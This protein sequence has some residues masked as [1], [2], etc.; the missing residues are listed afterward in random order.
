MFS[1][2]LPRRGACRL[3]GLLPIFACALSLELPAADAGSYILTPRPGPAPKINGPAVYGV[4]PGRPLLYRIPCTG[5]RPIRFSAEPLPGS[6]RLDAV[7]G[8]LTG[9]AP[10]KAGEYA[11]TLRAT[12]DHGQ[13]TKR[14]KIVVG[15]TLALTPPMGWN[16]WYTHYDRITDKLL[17]QAADAMVSSGMADFGYQYVNID[18]CWMVKPNSTNAEM[19]GAPR[20]EAGAIRP[21]HRFPDMPALAAYIHSR[22]LKAG[23]YTSPG[24]LT[25][26]GFT[27]SFQ[28][29]E[30]DARKFAEWGFD[31]L[32]Y[33]WC[34][35]RPAGD[36]KTLADYE[37][38]YKLMGGILPKMDRDIVFNLCQY[39][40]AD[41]WNWG[42]DVGGHSW[43]TTGDLGL[44]KSARLPGFYF[45][46]FKNAEHAASARPGR[47]ND[48]DYILIGSVGDAF[49]IDAPP[50]PTALT[51]DE[52]YSYMSM[53]SLM[54]APLLFSGDM[55]YLDE[56]T[57]NVLC[58]AEVIDV[59]QDLLG[60]QARV[61]RHNDNEFVLAKSLEDG[62][63]AV[64]LFNLGEAPAKLSVTWAEL[65]I[66]GPRRV[67]DLWRQKDAGPASDQY[68]AAVN[69]HG[70]ALVR[71]VRP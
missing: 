45:V 41:V 43:R 15:D 11:L 22:G 24:P 68:S 50:K 6:L 55:N 32:K 28:H 52:Q 63:V 57:L 49:H 42:G 25:C 16:D 18:D 1:L 61:I 54:A 10:Q 9:T 5:T 62:S 21:N 34:S 37:R 38:P 44:E 35:Y 48:P 39:G 20:D 65:G 59:D 67:R 29:E 30:I 51:P 7:T 3:L 46:G 47:W 14:W 53:W 66:D 56:F 8:I 17:R 36:G 69:R 19:A 71:L 27:G 31:F 2:S 23:L 26:G 58:N 4:R 33:D 64:G 13:A 70:V 12:N 60:K 40:M